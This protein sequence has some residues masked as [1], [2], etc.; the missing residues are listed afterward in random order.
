MIELYNEDCLKQM[1]LFKDN[2]VEV[3]FTSPPYNR[4]RNDKYELYDDTIIILYNTV[5]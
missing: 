5:W 4:K 3:S 1:K 2:M